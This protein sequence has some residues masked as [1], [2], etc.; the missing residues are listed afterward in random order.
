MTNFSRPEFTTIDEFHAA[1][2]ANHH[3]QTFRYYL[4]IEL[5]CYPRI[6][7]PHQF[8]MACGMI[9]F[10]TGKSECRYMEE[11]ASRLIS[12]SV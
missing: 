12:F 5:G 9:N 1:V 6:W 3:K 11:V 2:K 4:N 10:K 8:A 7:S